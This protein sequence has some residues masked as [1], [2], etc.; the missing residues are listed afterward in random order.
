LPAALREMRRVLRPGG[1]LLLAFHVGIGCLHC[2]VGGVYTAPVL[3]GTG[4]IPDA[5]TAGHA[6][7]G[8]HSR[9]QPRRDRVCRSFDPRLAC[10]NVPR[11]SQCLWNGRRVLVFRHG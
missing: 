3:R 6:A 5:Q 7:S 4:H 10:L 11:T 8:D 9:V 2:S 1:L